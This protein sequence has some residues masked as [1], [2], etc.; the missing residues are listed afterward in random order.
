MFPL[1]PFAGS[2]PENRRENLFENYFKNA[3]D[4]SDSP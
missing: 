4:K 2:S 3:V 1:Y